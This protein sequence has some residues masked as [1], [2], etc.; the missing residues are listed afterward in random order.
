[1]L[2]NAH[3]DRVLVDVTMCNE[4]EERDV[5]LML[6]N[7]SRTP[8][9]I[10]DRIEESFQQE[11]D[12]PVNNQIIGMMKKRYIGL[13]VVQTIKRVHRELDEARSR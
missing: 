8:R 2:F 3:P 13:K 11:V 4:R 7:L 6:M 5:I 10:L 9:D 1:V 12:R